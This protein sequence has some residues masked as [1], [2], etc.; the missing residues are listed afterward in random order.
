MTTRTAGAFSA[1][2]WRLKAPNNANV[3][4]FDHLADLSYTPEQEV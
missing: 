1:I 2:C 3:T 4:Q